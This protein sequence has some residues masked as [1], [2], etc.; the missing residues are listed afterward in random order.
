MEPFVENR[1]LTAEV[2]LEDWVVT[3]LLDD[4]SAPGGIQTDER[5]RWHQYLSQLDGSD[6]FF[7]DL[8]A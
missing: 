8:D 5:M 3:K 7:R 6:G 4:S 1:E 2:R